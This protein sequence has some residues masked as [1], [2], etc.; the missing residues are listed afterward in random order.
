MYMTVKTARDITKWL[1]IKRK[2]TK[3]IRLRYLKP[4]FRSNKNTIEA[5]LL[6]REHKRK[7]RNCMN[8]SNRKH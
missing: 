3:I 8:S 7:M 4:H 2:S 1:K 5:S 6:N